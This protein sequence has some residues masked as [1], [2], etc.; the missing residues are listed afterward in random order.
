MTGMW[1]PRRVVPMTLIG[2]PL[3][4][5]VA[6]VGTGQWRWPVTGVLAGAGLLA[7]IVAAVAFLDVDDPDV[8]PVFVLGL[9]VVIALVPLAGLAMWLWTGNGFWALTLLSPVLGLIVGGLLSES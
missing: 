2:P 5:V 6:W 1:S 9:L 4:G 7:V 8:G 3:L